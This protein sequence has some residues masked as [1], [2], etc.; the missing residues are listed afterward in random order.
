MFLGRFNLFDEML[1]NAADNKQRVS[2]MS[3][4]KTVLDLENGI[5]TCEYVGAGI[6]IA[7][8]SEHGIYP[9]V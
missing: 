5:I 4:I 1:V 8:H 7:M 6:S 3:R 2:K 9:S